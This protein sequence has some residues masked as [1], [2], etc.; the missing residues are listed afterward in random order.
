MCLVH[1]FSREK[2]KHLSKIP[3]KV[4]PEHHGGNGIPAAT[5]KAFTECEFIREITLV[6]TWL[7]NSGA[8]PQDRFAKCIPISKPAAAYC[9]LCTT[10]R[11]HK[12]KTSSKT[13]ILGFRIV[14]RQGKTSPKQQAS[15]TNYKGLRQT[16]QLPELDMALFN[17]FSWFT[18]I[19]KYKRPLDSYACPYQR[20]GNGTKLPN[21]FKCVKNILNCCNIPENGVPHLIFQRKKSE[22]FQ[23]FFKR[24]WG[25]LIKLNAT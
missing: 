19:Y 25:A 8:R 24:L 22:N 4:C 9:L 1:R 14:S 7:G 12:T 5:E 20:R 18:K 15:I 10:P 11:K 6:V 17:I 16:R 21:I 13:T 3:T 23:T 2:S